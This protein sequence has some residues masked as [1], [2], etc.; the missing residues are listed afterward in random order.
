M[1]RDNHAVGA[2]KGIGPKWRRLGKNEADGEVVDLLDRD[3]L[4]AGDRDR[5]GLRRSGIFPVEDDIV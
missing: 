5:R 3:V 4:V 1:F 2:N